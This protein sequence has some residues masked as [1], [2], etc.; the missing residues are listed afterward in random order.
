[1]FNLLPEMRRTN[2]EK[3]FTRQS[4]HVFDNVSFQNSSRVVPLNLNQTIGD[5]MVSHRRDQ[6]GSRLLS[7]RLDNEQL[8]IEEFG[9][10]KIIKEPLK[11]LE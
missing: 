3:G 11:T 4:S 10:D 5:P 8:V 1:M 2:F 6:S 7:R 9:F